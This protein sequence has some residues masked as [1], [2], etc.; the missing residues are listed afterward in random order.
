MSDANVDEREIE[1]RLAMLQHWYGD[2]LTDEQWEG[3]R[4]G[5][6]EE[7]IE[8]SEAL[9]SVVL[10]YADEPL[11]LFAPYRAETGR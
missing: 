11:P 6:V 7:V 9:Q 10:D 2:L 8:V 1:L 5:I 3:V 4:E